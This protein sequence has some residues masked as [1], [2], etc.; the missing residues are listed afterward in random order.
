MA[1]GT[2]I[3]T[4]VNDL[5]DAYVRDYF[6]HFPDDATAEGYPGADHG[7]LND[8]SLEAMKT[9]EQ[10]ENE[11]LGAL[12][13]IDAS[14]LIGSPAYVTYSFLRER[15]ELVRIPPRNGY[16]RGVKAASR[17]PAP[18][19]G[20]SQVSAPQY[21]DARFCSV[22]LHRKSL[23]IQLQSACVPTISGRLRPT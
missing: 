5:A 22:F 2:A 18:R 15:L 9:W 20:L 13:E 21:G 10:R 1:E 23:F 8:N 16:G 7:R 17:C 14:P 11:I 4:R 19:Q 6:E 3:A 12:R